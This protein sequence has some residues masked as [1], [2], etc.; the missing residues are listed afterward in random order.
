MYNDFFTSM[1]DEGAVL[2]TLV[3]IMIFTHLLQALA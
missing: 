3:D 2:G 1:V